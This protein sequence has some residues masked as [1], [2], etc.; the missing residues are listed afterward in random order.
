MNEQ[1]T[2]ADKTVTAKKVDTVDNKTVTHYLICSDNK[3]FLDE[4]VETNLFNLKDS[5]DLCYIDPPY[6]TGNVHTNGF[7][8]HDS[9]AGSEEWM[10]FMRERLVPTKHL[11]KDTGVITVSI[12]DSE[13]HHL[14]VLMDE[15]FGRNNFIAQIVVDGGNLKNNARFISTTHDYVL[16]YAK[17][18]AKLRISGIKWR[19]HRNGVDK[20]FKQLTKLRKQHGTDYDTISSEVK[21]WLRTAPVPKRV[22][23]F[24]NADSKGLYTYA[25]LSAPGNGQ[26]YDVL[27]P[28]TGLPCTVPS[29]GWGL[30]EDK[31]NAL[32]A[33][34]MIIFGKDEKAQPLK[35]LYLTNKKDQVQ[36]SMMAYPSRSSTH[37]LQK[38]L[39]RRS[40]FNNPKNL[41]MMM[42]LIDLICPEN[43]LVL[44]YF[45][46]S[47]TTGHAVLELNKKHAT[48]RK[49]VMVTNNENNIFN[50]VTFPRIHNVL[51]NYATSSQT[52]EQKVE[53]VVS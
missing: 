47:G 12:D 36:S 44:D 16:V 40:S 18:L 14:R 50:E 19:K 41:N 15:I 38:I 53:L 3:K 45:A 6:N 10:Q 39:G 46:G 5:V 35:K 34:D 32:L 28:S 4:E 26:C 20:L 37:L 48:S 51:T 49:F 23:T 8:Y 29:R 33:E 25:D 17:S 2:S 22:K 1:Q 21:T 52:V 43:G 31:M 24:Y 30:S 11:L 9:F 13:V 7:T 42:D 27:H